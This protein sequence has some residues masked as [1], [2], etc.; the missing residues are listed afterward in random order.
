[1][2]YTS[3][4]D[5]FDGGGAGRSGA[6]FQGGGLLSALANRFAKPIGSQRRS[7]ENLSNMINQLQSGGMSNK[8]IPNIIDM[9]G[10]VEDLSGVGI[11]EKINVSELDDISFK[12]FSELALPVFE[13]KG[14]TPSYDDLLRA[15]VNYLNRP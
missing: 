10:E 6:T 3:L 5:M 11:P 9:T 4:M 1:M 12:E 13:E 7:S 15:Y 14:V 2:A 8:S